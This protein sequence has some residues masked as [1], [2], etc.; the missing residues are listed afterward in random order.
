M[1]VTLKN[2]Q[3][4]PDIREPSSLVEADPDSFLSI[5]LRKHPEGKRAQWLRSFPA[6]AASQ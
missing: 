2:Y 4:E 5:S 3:T 1:Q 6:I